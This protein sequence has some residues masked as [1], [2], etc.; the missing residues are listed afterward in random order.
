MPD[1]LLHLKTGCS[2]LDGETILAVEALVASGL[3]EGYDLIALPAGEEAAANAIRVNG[4]VMIS[5][6]HD[7]T[8]RIL[9]D[10]GYDIV[11]LPTGQAALL[12]GGLSCMSLRF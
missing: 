8:A 1:G 3:F 2:L 12:D 7:L 11:E 6:G 10:R 9:S 4:Q 5:A